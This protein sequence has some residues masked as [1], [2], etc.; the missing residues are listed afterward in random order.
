MQITLKQFHIE[1]AI[2]DY[3]TKAGITFDVEEIS[4]TAG[5]GKDGMTATV[6]L[7]DPFLAA[8]AE[9]EVA[10][11]ADAPKSIKACVKRE[12]A[13]DTPPKEA[14]K[15]AAAKSEEANSQDDPV[16]ETP[17]VAF[18]KEEPVFGEPANDEETPSSPTPVEKGVSLFG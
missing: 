1:A 3:V 7:E 5:R 12:E 16:E 10:Q 13:V 9:H 4:F 17:D 18:S 8:E 15:G 14:A 11:S 6:E 2:R